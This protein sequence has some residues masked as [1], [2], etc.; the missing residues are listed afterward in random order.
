MNYALIKRTI[1]EALKTPGFSLLYIIGVAMAIAFTMI[2]GILLYGQLGPVYPEYDRDSTIYLGGVKIMN[3]GNNIN[4]NFSKRFVDDYLRDNLKSVSLITT[5][6]SYNPRS[7]KIQTDGRGPEFKV[8]LRKVDPAFFELYN[9]SFLAGKPFT[10]ADFD[11]KLRTAAISDKVAARLFDSPEDAIGKHIKI[12][13]V[14]YRVAGVFREGNALSVDSYGEVFTPYYFDGVFDGEWPQELAG[15]L[16]VTVKVKPGKKEDLAKELTD[17]CQ[18][19]NTVD[20]ASGKVYIPIIETH[21]EHVLSDHNVEV[22]EQS[23][24]VQVGK[25]QFSLWKPMIIALLIVLVIPALNITGL[26][27]SRMD[28]LTPEIGI[29][30]SFGATRHRL[31]IMVMTENLVLTIIGGIIGLVAAWIVLVCARDF[32]LQFTPLSYINNPKFGASVS[33]MTGEMA[34]AP[35]IFIGAFAVCLVLNTISA[36]IPARRAIHRQITDAINTKR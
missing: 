4:A 17:I 26:I 21:K 5:K 2:Y 33:F 10:Q 23:F 9:Y 16:A 6:I 31:M 1:K 19:L 18:R 13:R 30:R 24:K 28:R 25:S 11:S 14:N 27:R 36:W 8:V 32:L 34:F 3:D 29:R 20:T 7:P 35:V 12:D 15:G 22:D